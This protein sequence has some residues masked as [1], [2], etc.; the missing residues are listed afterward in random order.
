MKR[1]KKNITKYFEKQTERKTTTKTKNINMKKIYM[2]TVQRYGNIMLRYI[3]EY[4]KYMEREGLL[5]KTKEEKKRNNN[6]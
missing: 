2:E 6:L 3:R 1:K 5:I 4:K